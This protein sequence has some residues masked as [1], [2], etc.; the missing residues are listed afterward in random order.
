MQREEIQVNLGERSYPILVTSG[1][2]MGIG[3]FARSRC[4]GTRTLVVCD[5]N[6]AA[7]SA[8][9]SASLNQAGFVCVTVSL[10]PGESS[11]SMANATT[12]FDALIRMA[13]DRQTLVVAV[14]G[15]VIGDLA[16]FV[17]ATYARGVPFLQVPTSLL[18]QVDSS[19][20]GKVGINHATPDGRV[21]KN[22]IGAFHQP[23]GVY[24]DT[25]TLRTLPPLELRAGLAEVVKCGVILD[26]EFFAFLESNA[27]A[28]LALEPAATRHVV[29]RC[30]RLKADVVEADE[31]ETT[32]RRAILNYGHT[33]AHA[34]EAISR[35]YRH[36][37]AVAIGMV[38]ASRLAERLGRVPPAVTERQVRLLE[39]FGL[40]T[41]ARNLDPA[42]LL[43]AMQHDKKMQAG[44]LR[45]VL[46]RGLGKVELVSRV[47]RS[48]VQDVIEC[49][50][51]TGS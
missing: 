6:T 19:V 40:P 42:G 50:V 39:R 15:G 12:L 34:I 14:G 49:M 29:A 38:A 18:A 32:D 33:F 48:L 28:V 9:V 2:L 1:E 21:V 17:A 36:G 46:P 7:I 24:I 47:E 51:R 20:G 27:D 5:G 13:A 37:E 30:C 41:H 45:F 10:A 8:T 35:D 31:R 43:E 4:R 26:E 3:Q 44:Q 11:K 16:G 22:M 23:A 25:D